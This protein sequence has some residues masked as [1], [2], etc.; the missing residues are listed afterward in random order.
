LIQGQ[1]QFLRRITFA[2]AGISVPT[3]LLPDA[4]KGARPLSHPKRKRDLKISYYHWLDGK[5]AEVSSLPHSIQT[6]VF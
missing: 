6:L 5:A 3:E 2:D 1:I 4:H